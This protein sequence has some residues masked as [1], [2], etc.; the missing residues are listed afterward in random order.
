M[1]LY[2]WMVFTLYNVHEALYMK[3]DAVVVAAADKKKYAN[4]HAQL[5]SALHHR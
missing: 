2:L 3:Y 1:F 4:L 5:K